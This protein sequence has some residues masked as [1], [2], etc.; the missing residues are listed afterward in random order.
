MLVGE[1]SPQWAKDLIGYWIIFND[2]HHSC[3]DVKAF[4]YLTD[5]FP[6]N[7]E[8]SRVRIFAEL[9]ESVLLEVETDIPT[10]GVYATYLLEGQYQIINFPYGVW[11]WT[12]KQRADLG[13]KL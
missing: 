2:H 10:Q 5:C 9:Y 8:R 13:I 6:N 4:V 12:M 7:P 3:N 1:A 11:G